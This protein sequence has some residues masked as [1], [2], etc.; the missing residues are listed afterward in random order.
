MLDFR[1]LFP[2]RVTSS[3]RRWMAVAALTF[4]TTPATTAAPWRTVGAQKIPDRIDDATFW[5]MVVDMSE[6]GGY[7]R[8][9][10]FV[11]NE[12][13]FQQVIPRLKEA[14]GAGGVYVGVGPDQN[15]T[16]IAALKPRVAFVVDIRRQNMLQHLLYKSFIEM[17]KDRAEFAALL[18][19]R[20]RP[21]DADTAWTAETL[22]AAIA[23]APLDSTRF[24]RLLTAA[25]DRLV[26]Q[27]GF[28]LSAEDLAAIRYVYTAFAT[29]GPSI[30]YSFGRGVMGP[31][32]RRTMPTFAEL[33][34]ETD[35][36]GV[37]RSYLASEANFRVLKDLEERNLI[38][39]LVGDFAGDKAIRSVGT[40]IKDHRATV[41]VFYTSNVEQYLFQSPD[42]WKRYYTSVATMPLDAS[43]TF[44]R[45]VFGYGV[46]MTGPPY[47]MRSSTLLSGIQDLLT[48]FDEGRVQ[49]YFDVIQMSRDGEHDEP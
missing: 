41:S 3:T 22:L 19:S 8:S 43:S 46:S 26:K 24:E 18:F 33:M 25:T 45:A 20:E 15:F 11:S 12:T 31:Y 4:A 40:W 6:P 27:H 38:I 34:A 14:V 7:F 47:G 23:A 16:Y 49:S 29:T 42:N 2:W 39:P 21:A 5:A 10:N 44:I 36:Q 35:G 32:G 37:Q 48:A 30:S 17:A 9:D 28:N 1:A 13:S